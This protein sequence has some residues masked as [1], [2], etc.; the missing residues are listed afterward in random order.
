MEA[1]ENELLDVDWRSE[2]LELNAKAMYNCA[3]YYC[4]YARNKRQEE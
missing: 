2:L 3:N 1:I 4:R